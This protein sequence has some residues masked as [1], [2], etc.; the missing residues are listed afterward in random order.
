MH[1]VLKIE[2]YGVYYKTAERQLVSS[3]PLQ[4][5]HEFLQTYSKFVPDTGRIVKH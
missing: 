1:K 2:N 5:R 3:I 4:D